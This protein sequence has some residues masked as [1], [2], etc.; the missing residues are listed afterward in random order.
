VAW[1]RLHDG[2]PEHPKLEV[3]GD[4][5]GWLF[6]CALCY[7]N[8]AETDGFVPEGRVGKLTGLKQP[9]KAAERLVEVGLFDR[10]EGGYGIHDYHD[11]QPSAA[12]L[13]RQR[14]QKAARMARWRGKRRP[15]D[16]GVDASTDASRDAEGDAG[17]TLAPSPSPNKGR[18][19]DLPRRE[20]VEDLC[21]LL[22]E[23]IHANG[24]PVNRIGWP[25]KGWRDAAR[26]MLDRDSRDLKEA[27]T[28]I[29]WC[30]AD[31]FWRG[32]VESMPTFRRQYDKLRL[33][34]IA[35]GVLR[36]AGQR[37]KSVDTTDA[38]LAR[39]LQ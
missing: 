2:F 23:L 3:A 32:N 19:N 1:V 20:D 13:K 21:S 5:A 17:E 6:V 26:L 39:A 9:H 29:R 11:Y 37:P 34:A 25:S 28:L 8:R 30:Q 18:S 35:A 22:A 16:G 10:V 27:E 4:E 33:K 15:S 24:T 7:C 31:E 12:D 14:E 36:S 38:D